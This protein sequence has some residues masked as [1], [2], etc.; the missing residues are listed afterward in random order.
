MSFFFVLVGLSVWRLVDSNQS[1]RPL[2]LLL[3]WLLGLPAKMGFISLRS[4]RR[5]YSSIL[6][7]AGV[8][9]IF[10]SL[11]MWPI[12]RGSCFSEEVYQSHRSHFGAIPGFPENVT[13]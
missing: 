11:R 7:R 12:F 13:M 6:F 2:I 8:Q 3:Y 1:F 9:M 5:L 10:R 4:C